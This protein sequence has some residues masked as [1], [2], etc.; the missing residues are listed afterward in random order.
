MRARANP[1]R[2]AAVADRGRGVLGRVLV[3]WTCRRRQLERTQ[4]T[5]SRAWS[6]ARA[7]AA[8][9]LTLVASHAPKLYAAGAEVPFLGNGLAVEPASSDLVGPDEAGIGSLIARRGTERWLVLFAYGER[10][11][12]LGNGSLA[13]ATAVVDGVLGQPNDYY[14]LYLMVRSD[15]LDE[16]AQREVVDLARGLFPRIAAWYAA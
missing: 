3:R 2:R 13:W 4:R 12:L 11:G 1:R 9:T 8:G 15:N 14:K 10:R 16:S 5:W 7:G 6:E